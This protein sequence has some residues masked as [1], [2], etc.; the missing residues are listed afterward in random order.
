MEAEKMTHAEKIGHI[1]YAAKA[2]ITPAER[3]RRS[4]F[5]VL[6]ASAVSG[7]IA[8]ITGL[9]ISFMAFS[10][11]I[12]R[13]RTTSLLVSMLIVSS[14]GLLLFAAHAMDRSSE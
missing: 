2:E 11:L 6:C 13:T 10:H 4:W 9:F 12:E 3:R 5:G 1:G 14:L 7:F 8:G